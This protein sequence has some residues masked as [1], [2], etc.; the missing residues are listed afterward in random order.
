MMNELTKR[1]LS[2]VLILPIAIYLI[3]KG[4]FFFIF[5]LIVVFFVS[6]FEWLNMSKRLKILKFFGVFFILLSIISAY[7]LRNIN[8]F[9]IF[10]FIIL[11]SILTDIGGYIFGKIL[12]GPKLTKISPQKT[13]SGAIGGFVFSITGG[14]IYL[15][16]FPNLFLWTFLDGFDVYEIE[17]IFCWSIFII[18]ISFVSQTGDLII[19]YFKRLANMKD[20]GAIIPGH[21][22]LLDR[23]DGIIFAVPFSY[24]I[25]NYG[26]Y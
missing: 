17:N 1:L 18:L 26:I 10:T 8:G 4:S 25:L 15:N 21:G 16:Y 20:T 23:I 13:Y 19:S 12:K 22:G 3:S 6:I 2:S 11:I 14:L 7:F 9:E 24:I 5:F